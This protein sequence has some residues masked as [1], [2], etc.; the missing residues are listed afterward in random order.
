[1][2]LAVPMKLVEVA[3]SGIRGVA[4]LAEVRYDVDLSLLEGAQ[5]G[6]YLIVHAGFAIEKLDEN[7]ALERI[8]MFREIA[9][10]TS[11]KS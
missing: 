7:E 10:D 11:D 2:C 5:T 6:D 9:G 4:L 8:A 1:M 3:P